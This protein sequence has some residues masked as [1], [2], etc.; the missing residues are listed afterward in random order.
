[1]NRTPTTSVEEL[2][3]ALKSAG[4]RPAL[5]LIHRGDNSL[6]VTVKRANG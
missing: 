6:F 5:V 4:D 2:R 1:V 3:A